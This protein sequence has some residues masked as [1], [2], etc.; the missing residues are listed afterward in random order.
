MEKQISIAEFIR[1]IR[2]LPSDEPVDNPRKWYTTQKEHWLGWLREYE[3]PGA[4]GRKTGV[5]RDARFAY[6]HV[7]CPE[8]LMY[9][10]RA[11]PLRQELVEAAENAYE[12]GSSEMEKSGAIRRVVPWSE[13]YRAIWGTGKPSLARRVGNII[14]QGLEKQ[15]K[16]PDNSIPIDKGNGSPSNEPQAVQNRAISVRQPYADQILCGTKKIEYRSIVTHIRGRV[17]VYAS[18]RPDLDAYQKLKIKPGSLPTG[19]IVGTVEI[20]GCDGIDGE[21][22]WHLA[23]PER[24]AQPIKPERHPQPVW[25]KPFHEAGME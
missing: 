21:Y 13:I 9:L 5:K 18:Q 8:L 1:A 24:L 3:G 14:Q 7:V 12:S 16:K 4:Y 25:F 11:I 17:Y 23:R 10:I 2:R 15:K 6:N 20:I 22:E 19:V